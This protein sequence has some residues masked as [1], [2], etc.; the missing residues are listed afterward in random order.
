MHCVF[1]PEIDSNN[2]PLLQPPPHWAFPCS[3]RS[4]AVNSLLIVNNSVYP[5]GISGLGNSLELCHMLD[6]DFIQKICSSP[7]KWKWG[8]TFVVDRFSFPVF[9]E[10]C[11]HVLRSTWQ[12]KWEKPPE[13]P[14]ENEGFIQ[15]DG[16]V[17][18][19][20]AALQKSSHSMTGLKPQHIFKA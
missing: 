18:T 4:T 12:R 11:W 10:G 15:T 6:T 19:W 5:K 3:F 16:K 13:E 7:L 1:K 9:E 20:T 17:N 8:N 2:Y 14:E